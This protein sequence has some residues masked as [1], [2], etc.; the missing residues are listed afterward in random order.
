MTAAIRAL[1][2]R[3][4]A[5]IE[6]GDADAALACYAPDA[7]IW[8]NTDGL[9]QDVAA[10]ARTLRGLIAVTTARRYEDR[11]LEVLPTGF[12]QQHVLVADRPDR[13]T[14]HLPACLI[15]AVAADR[16]TRLD[17]YFDSRAL[18]VWR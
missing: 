7:R 10:N 11:R 1:A 12:V 17:E 3:F 18:D 16:I 5:A 4:F 15:C 6:A 8:H 13:P 9:E 14:L 2:D